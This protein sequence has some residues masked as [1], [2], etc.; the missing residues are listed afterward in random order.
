MQVKFILT[1]RF[2]TRRRWSENVWSTE[3]EVISVNEKIDCKNKKQQ[4]KKKQD[5][6][7]A[8]FHLKTQFAISTDLKTI[9]W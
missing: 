2:W 3:L 5:V 4:K 8:T 6:Q 9:L 1:N 7:N